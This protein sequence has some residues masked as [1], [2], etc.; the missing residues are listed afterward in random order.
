MAIFPG[1]AITPA[2][3]GAGYTID[4]SLRFNDDDDAYLNWTPSSDGNRQAWTY[5]TW[6]KR[7]NVGSIDLGIFSADGGSSGGAYAEGIR[8]NFDKLYL[9]V[10]LTTI[11][12]TTALFRDPS[13]WYHIVVVWD[14]TNAT[15]SDR[16]RLYVNGERIT[17]F[18]TL[19]LPSLNDNSG[20]FNRGGTI[21]HRIGEYGCIGCYDYK[22]DGYMA[23][24]HFIDG[25]ALDPSYFGETD[26]DYGHWKPIA[27]TGSYGTNGFYLDF[28]NSG[29]IGEDQAGSND[30]T[31]NNLAATDVVLDSPTNNFATFNP[32]QQTDGV[33]AF[34]EGNLW[35]NMGSTG[36]YHYIKST[37]GMSSGKWYCEF[38][39]GSNSANDYGLSVYSIKR[40]AISGNLGGYLDSYTVTYHANSYLYWESNQRTTA[41]QGGLSAGDIGMIAV[42]M[43]AGKVWFGKNGTWIDSGN[44]STGANATYS[45][46]LTYGDTWFFGTYGYYG[47][48]DVWA[49]FGQDSSF[50]GNKTAQNNTDANGYGDFYYAP[51]SGFLALCTANLPDPAVV[52]GENFNTVL[53]TGDGTDGRAISGVGFQPDLV[54]VKSRSTDAHNVLNDAVRGHSHNIYSNLTNAENT[55]ALI[56]DFNADGFD[57]GTA[58]ST[59]VETNWS[60]FTYVA[61]NWKANNTSGST[62]TDGSITST[63]AANA[64]AGFS[65]VSYTGT[66]SAGTIGHG[67]SSAPD[68]IILKRRSNLANWLVYSSKLTSATY[69]LSLNQTI[70]QSAA[71]TVWNSTDPTSTAFSIGTDDGVNAS[72]N[73]Y[74]AYCFHSVDGYSKFGSYTGNGSSNGPF[75]YTGFRPAFV[76]VKRTD[77]ADDWYIRDSVREP[78][79]P[80]DA[81]IY[82]DLSY[83]EDT[84]GGAAYYVDFLSNG[85]KLKGSGGGFNASGGTYIY[86]CFSEYPFK[87]TNAR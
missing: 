57:V 38:N 68:I 17:A 80:T 82:A 50:A 11:F 7:G 55:L 40:D 78:E 63:V 19:N 15:S 41:D 21:V 42:D 85:F 35:F 71:S 45:S 70:A 59:L 87:F 72:G 9:R 51:P 2:G 86:A 34:A 73:T 33:A 14:T 27:Y 8:L 53:W 18:D 10:N 48:T 28:S 37:I 84:S 39:M 62:N 24:V 43:D 77:G 1:T 25:Q 67:L 75:V 81:T 23:E 66:G 16:V 6:V 36:G 31:A 58:S 60:G 65:I 54:W 12:N 20:A 49:N 22:F 56:T 29:S 69:Y 61:W 79:N 13:A 5:S 30:W 46:L 52:P 74:I 64:D 44:P 32:V 76:M 26:E 3:G 83:A 4:Q 47:G